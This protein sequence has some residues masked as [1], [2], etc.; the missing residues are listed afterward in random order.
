MTEATNPFAIG[1]LLEELSWEGRNVRGYRAGGL[2]RENVLTTH[3]LS[4]LDYLPRSEFLGGVL[5]GAAGAD[6]ARETLVDECEDASF[7]VLP[8]ELL[9]ASRIKIQPDAR[10]LSA[11]CYMMVEAKGPKRSSFQPEQLARE[12]LALLDVTGPRRPLLLLM[13]GVAPPIRVQGSG[14]MTIEDATGHGLRLLAERGVQTETPHEEL[15]ERLPEILSWTTWSKISD[16]VDDLVNHLPESSSIDRSILR[17]AK[18][19]AETLKWHTA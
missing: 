5:R 12:Y 15:L 8:D 4:L 3:A 11:S 17:V 6:V 14:L 10:I 2:G 9:L 16:I 18:E 19:L 7:M 13:L 1:R